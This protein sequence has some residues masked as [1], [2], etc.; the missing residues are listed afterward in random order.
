MGQLQEMQKAVQELMNLTANN[1]TNNLKLLENIFM[2]SD[3]DHH[4]MSKG[5][6]VKE[7]I[8]FCA[9]GFILAEVGGKSSK[10]QLEVE[11]TENDKEYRQAMMDIAYSYLA[12][13]KEGKGYFTSDEM[14]N[15]TSGVSGK[16][17]ASNLL[18]PA[19]WSEMDIDY[20]GRI[21]FEEFV[22]AF[23]MWVTAGDDEE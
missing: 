16:K 1:D 20:S 17:D 12:F 13:D 2:L 15:A 11:E 18:T 4:G 23:S 22:Y 19:R 8:I 3:L 14:H 6:D 9:V 21:D 5:L 10:Q 7:F